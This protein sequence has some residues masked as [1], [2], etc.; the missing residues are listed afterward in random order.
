[1]PTA[2][3][4]K[5][6][7]H[8]V[9]ETGVDS[10]TCGSC[11]AKLKLR[12][13]PKKPTDSEAQPLSPGSP[14]AKAR[15]APGAGSP[16]CL[17]GKKRLKGTAAVVAAVLGVV[18]VAGAVIDV[19]GRAGPGGEADV[20]D[21]AA[22]QLVNA[23]FYEPLVADAKWRGKW[24]RMEVRLARSSDSPGRGLPMLDGLVCHLSKHDEARFLA[25]EPGEDDYVVV[26]KVGKYVRS[27]W[28]QEVDLQVNLDK[29][30][31]V[32]TDEEARER[33]RSRAEAKAQQSA[34][35]K[36]QS[37]AELEA[38]RRRRE[39]EDAERERLAAERRAQEEDARKYYRV[40]SDPQAKVPYVTQ[41]WSEARHQGGESLVAG[42]TYC[43]PCSGVV[44]VG[45]SRIVSGEAPA[46]LHGY[47]HVLGCGLYRPACYLYFDEGSY[48]KFLDD[49]ARNA[50]AM[51]EHSPRRTVF[52]LATYRGQGAKY[53]EFLFFVDPRI[54]E[55]R[56]EK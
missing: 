32:E 21:V 10:V 35:E 23:Y 39:A 19:V 8:I 20:T 44:D 22:Y 30:R 51:G 45:G 15:P 47:P 2:N 41:A 31:I 40:P 4:P 36:A 18:A 27:S 6:G 9:L 33:R 5:C 37:D 56:E 11:G 1:M 24:V 34:L 52:I 50:L 54:V 38:V 13:A 49:M 16:G 17:R 25:A 48:K 3:C 12:T 29:C 42:K 46:G 28:G 7:A 55:V 53:A 14:S 43:I 26:G